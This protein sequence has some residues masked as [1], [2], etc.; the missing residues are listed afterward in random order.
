MDDSL[1]GPWYSIMWIP[2]EGG[3]TLLINHGNVSFSYQRFDR[4][5]SAEPDEPV[6]APIIVGVD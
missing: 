2:S 4:D 1:T 6:S 3:W 5:R